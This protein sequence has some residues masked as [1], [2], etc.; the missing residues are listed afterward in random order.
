MI[1]VCKKIRPPGDRQGVAHVAEKSC[2]QRLHN[3][4]QLPWPAERLARV[5]SSFATFSSAETE[6]KVED[7]R[8]LDA[9]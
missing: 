9:Q 4:V 1:T 5:G 6:E 8:G 2:A 3:S 7:D